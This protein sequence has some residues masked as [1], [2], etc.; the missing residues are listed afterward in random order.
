MSHYKKVRL[1]PSI[2]GYYVVLSNA[3]I[4]WRT[5]KQTT[6]SRSS[7][8]AEYHSM[9][10]ITCELTWLRYLLH[11]LCIDHSEPATLYCDN[12]GAIHIA[13]NPIYHERTKHI[14]LDCHI[15]REIIQ[16]GEIET[17]CVQTGK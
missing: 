12:Q 8:E 5:K 4:A 1:G 6:I 13:A 7:A 15:V 17:V 16:K 10:A 3:L 11:D 2:S 14:E 9:T